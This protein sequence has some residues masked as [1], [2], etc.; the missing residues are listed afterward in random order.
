MEKWVIISRRLVLLKKKT[1]NYIEI[2]KEDPPIVNASADDEENL[3]MFI[4]SHNYPSI[5]LD[6]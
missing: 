4:H 5:Y 2:V 6:R 1:R 3:R